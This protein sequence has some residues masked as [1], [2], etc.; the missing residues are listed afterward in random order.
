M[1]GYLRDEVRERLTWLQIV[2]LRG[3][4]KRGGGTFAYS[5]IVKWLSWSYCSAGRTLHR[6]YRGNGFKPRSSLN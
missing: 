6:C 1:E 4:Q 2:I 5:F 3:R